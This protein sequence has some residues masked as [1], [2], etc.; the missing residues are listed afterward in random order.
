MDKNILNNKIK[1]VWTM[2]K[3]NTPLSVSSYPDGVKMSQKFFKYPA[4]LTATWYDHGDIYFDE[5]EMNLIREFSRYIMKKD[6]TYPDK[7]AKQI[8]SLAKTIDQHNADNFKNKNLK[9][10]I[11]LFKKEKKMFLQMI[12]FISYRG[13][14]QMSEILREHVETLLKYKLAEIKS[15][16]LFQAYLDAL[17]YPLYESVVA[18]EKKFTLQLAINFPKISDDEQ[19][20]RI[21]LYLKKFEWLSF[22]WFVGV[23][24]TRAQ[25]KN[26]LDRLATNA[27][28]ELSKIKTEEQKNEDDV[29]RIV[30]KLKFNTEEELL[31][32]QYRSWLF[33]RTFVKD[34]INKAAFKLLPILHAI[35]DAKQ[36]DQKLITFLTL[37][38]IHNIGRLTISE[39]SKLTNE[40]KHGFSAGIIG[41]KFSFRTFDK[42]VLPEQN[43]TETQIKGSIAFKGVVKGVAKVIF[44]PKEQNNLKRGEILVTSMT[45]PDLLPAMEHAAA[46]V[47]DEGGITCHAAIVAREMKKP[48]IIG[49]KIATKVLKNGDFIEVDAING[50]VKIIRRDDEKI[51]N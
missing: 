48:C 22:H 20:K 50:I 47:T 23:P 41:N 42:A 14:V 25:I 39:I 18:E 9:Q 21:S 3:L 35:A 1:W 38:E 45:T 49:T 33:L 27:K 12:G 37:E 15:L 4:H 51:S 28:Q 40:R 17:S 7:I 30:R 6:Q 13:S 19:E 10:L 43:I 44:S 32:K 8:F 2:R 46:F 34:N 36:I 11:T 24:P 16:N 5:E 29:R 31:L 26:K